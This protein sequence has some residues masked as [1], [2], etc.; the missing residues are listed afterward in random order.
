M[1]IYRQL[2]ADTQRTQIDEPTRTIGTGPGGHCGA[3]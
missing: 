2:L 3:L 1:P